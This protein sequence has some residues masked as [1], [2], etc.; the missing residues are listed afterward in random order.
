[1]GI[2]SRDE[3]QE[4]LVYFAFCVSVSEFAIYLCVSGGQSATNPDFSGR[5]SRK[6]VK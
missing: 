5:I 4:E 1:M 6:L 2:L 3:A